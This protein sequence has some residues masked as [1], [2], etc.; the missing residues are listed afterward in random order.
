MVTARL[1]LPKCSGHRGPKGK[2][3]G[4]PADAEAP[5]LKTKAKKED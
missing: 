1:I 5:L 3:R 4:A 2:N